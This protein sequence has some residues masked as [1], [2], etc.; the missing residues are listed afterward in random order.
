MA[1]EDYKTIADSTICYTVESEG[2]GKE[3]TGLVDLND[4]FGAC[5]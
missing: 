5:W 1:S 3:E 4:L 2:P